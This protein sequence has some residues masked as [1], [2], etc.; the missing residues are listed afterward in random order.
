MATTPPA[1]DAVTDLTVDVDLAF[2][3]DQARP[4]VV[5]HQRDHDRIHR[6]LRAIREVWGNVLVAAQLGVPTANGTVGIATLDSSGRVPGSQLPPASA[7]P[8]AVT[9]FSG[10]SR[11]LVAADA[12]RLLRSLSATACT[13]V[14]PSDTAQTIPVGSA[15]ALMQGA[16]GELTVSGGASGASSAVRRNLLEGGTD[17]QPVTTAYSAGGDPFDEVV[18]VTFSAA[19]AA[20]GT[21][22]MRATLANSLAAYI[23]WF[24][25]FGPAVAVRDVW[26]VPTAPMNHNVRLVRAVQSGGAVAFEVRYNQAGEIDLVNTAGGQVGI[27]KDAGGVNFKPAANTTY[28]TEVLVN[29]TTGAWTLNVYTGRWAGT[30][31]PVASASGTSSFAAVTIVRIG[32]LSGT[33]IASAYVDHDDLALGTSLPLGAQGAVTVRSYGSGRTLAGQWA[34]ATLTKIGPN[35]W[36]LEGNVA[37]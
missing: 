28:T 26:K 36:W 24:W 21:M 19:A 33:V 25:S 32:D 18:G 14:C 35:E 11:T 34:G 4:G 2:G 15:F 37:A 16:S 20:E 6:A 29:T 27:A 8:G 1:L 3:D 10:T 13:V 7:V 17:G 9:T 23:G 5:V 31:S 22:G 12:D 30:G